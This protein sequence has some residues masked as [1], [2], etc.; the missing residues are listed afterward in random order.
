MTA[1]REWLEA[2]WSGGSSSVLGDLAKEVPMAMVMVRAR[3]G[4]HERRRSCREGCSYSWDVRHG[5][6]ECFPDS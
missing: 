2:A 1:A 5:K 3:I 4:V 6:P